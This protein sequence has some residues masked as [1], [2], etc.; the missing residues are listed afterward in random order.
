MIKKNI[1][2][3]LNDDNSP[4]KVG[5]NVNFSPL[6]SENQIKNSNNQ[7]PRMSVRPGN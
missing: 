6:R 3:E 7:I 4:I 1:E 2:S 5:I